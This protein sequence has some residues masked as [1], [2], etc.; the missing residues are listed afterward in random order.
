MRGW[1]PIA[2]LLI[3]CPVSVLAAGREELLAEARRAMLAARYC[4]LVTHGAGG[5]LSTRTMDPLP[6]EA[7]FQVWMATHP[8]S[9]KVAELRRNPRVTLHYFDEK[10]AA[11]VSLRGRATLVGEAGAKG[12]HWKG[13]WAPFYPDRDKGLILIQVVPDSLEVSSPGK[14]VPNDP[15]TWAAPVV[16]FHRP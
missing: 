9:R 4:T 3:L 1:R 5:T 11:T 6:P 8:G 16:S 2:A 10:A 15:A 14:G 7:G 12:G 13:E